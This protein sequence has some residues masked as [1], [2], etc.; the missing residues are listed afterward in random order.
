M[1]EVIELALVKDKV[2][3]ALD[4]TFKESIPAELK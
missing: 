1:K 3:D 2:K 4:L